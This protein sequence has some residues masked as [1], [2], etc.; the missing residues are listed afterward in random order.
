MKTGKSILFSNNGKGGILKIFRNYL[1][2]QK[3][4]YIMYTAFCDL[5]DACLKG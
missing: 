3:M 2:Y 1:H 5:E 4:V